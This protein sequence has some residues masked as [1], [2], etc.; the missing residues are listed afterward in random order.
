MGTINK[1][2]LL[3]KIVPFYCLLSCYLVVLNGYFDS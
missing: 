3:N 2:K 1:Q